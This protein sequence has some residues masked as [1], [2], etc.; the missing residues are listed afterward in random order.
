MAAI[1]TIEETLLERGHIHLIQGQPLKVLN[2]PKDKN[3]T[4]KPKGKTKSSAH[5]QAHRSAAPTS[6]AMGTFATKGS[7]EAGSSKSRQASHPF[8][9]MLDREKP[10]HEKQVST[11]KRAISPSPAVDL[12]KKKKA[13]H[14]RACSICGQ[15][16]HHLAIECPVVI[17][18]PTRYVQL[19]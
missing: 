5:V 7:D 16:P 13:K 1:R 17:Q 18:G 10:D 11:S 2:P 19:A 12:P 8:G 14:G 15:S 9:L 4:P 3:N 6:S